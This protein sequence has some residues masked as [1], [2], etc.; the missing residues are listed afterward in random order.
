MKKANLIITFLL[1]SIG[2]FSQNSILWEISG[3]GLKSS[4]YL[5]GT[6]KF[7]GEKEF[8]LPKEA[9]SKMGLQNLCP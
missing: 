1:C 9:V 6:L 4:S 2:A 3:N 7:I 8:Y 5:M